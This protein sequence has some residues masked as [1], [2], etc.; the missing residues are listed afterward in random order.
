MVW[1]AVVNHRGNKNVSNPVCFCVSALWLCRSAVSWTHLRLHKDFHCSL[2]TGQCEWI[3]LPPR[4]LCFSGSLIVVWS[5]SLFLFCF[6]MWPKS[7]KFH[8]QWIICYQRPTSALIIFYL[9]CS[10][11]HSVSHYYLKLNL[12]YVEL[13]IFPCKIFSLCPALGLIPVQGAALLPVS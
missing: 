4:A 8:K 5:L 2:V 7:N 9:N 1:S 12:I 11:D 6:C 3:I 10:F 13:F